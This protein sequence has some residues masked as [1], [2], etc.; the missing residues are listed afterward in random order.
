VLPDLPIN[1][2]VWRAAYQL[3][4]KARSRGITVPATDILIAAC[5]KCHEASLESADA[6]FEALAA[7]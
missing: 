4:R 5:A 7:L 1:E 3:A 2:A 6:D